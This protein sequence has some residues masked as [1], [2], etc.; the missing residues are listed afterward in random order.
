MTLRPPHLLCIAP[1]KSEGGVIS[2]FS[3]GTTVFVDLGATARLLASSAVASF[4]SQMFSNSYASAPRL[5]PAL[6]VL[7]VNTIPRLTI[8]QLRVPP[9]FLGKYTVSRFDSLVTTRTELDIIA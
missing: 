1:L 5:Q 9:R 3:V 4:P 7:T 6:K 8:L 2:K